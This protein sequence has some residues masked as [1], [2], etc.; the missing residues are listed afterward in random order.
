MD[1]EILEYE[2]M[3]EYEVNDNYDKEIQYDDINLMDLNLDFILNSL[4]MNL[5]RPKDLDE[6]GECFQL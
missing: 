1:A 4:E 6:T 3:L 5:I 2:E